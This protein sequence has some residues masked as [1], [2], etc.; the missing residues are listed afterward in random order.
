MTADRSSEAQEPLLIK[1]AQEIA[2]IEAENTL[3]Q[4]DSAMSELKIW[5]G[6]PHYRLKPSLLL[7]LNRI[8]LNSLSRYAGVFRPSDVK[9]S[10]STHQPPA[11]ADVPELVEDFC[12]YI[13][14]N[15]N[16]RTALHLCAYAL[17]RINWIHPFVDGNGRTARIISYI[18]LCA[19]LGYRLPGTK[20]V[21]EQIALN[22]QPYYR[23]LEAAD[24]AQRV[25]SIDVTDLE[26]LLDA[27]LAAQLVEIHEKASGAG[28]NERMA[29]A[30]YPDVPVSKSTPQLKESIW[31]RAVRH[32]ETHPVLYGLVGV[33]V[34][35][36]VAVVFGA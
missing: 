15:W 29:I 3:R 27:H 4:F 16:E 10:G 23:A 19:K 26:A 36:V 11:A 20:T 32:V 30:A 34:T 1:D 22:K 31:R 13:N 21:P 35:A 7:R 28:D 9:I 17:W 2:R 24:N 8:A 25:G 14:K 33:L 18:I 6:N 12:D 5:I